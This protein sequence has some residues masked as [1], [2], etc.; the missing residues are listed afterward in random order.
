[1]EKNGSGSQHVQVYH[2]QRLGEDHR[3][4]TQEWVALAETETECLRCPHSALQLWGIWD[5]FGKFSPGMFT[6]QA[7]TA[8]ISLASA[9]NPAEVSV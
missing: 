7:D 6:K 5:S 2:R 8:S 1:M 3:G 4:G 9:T